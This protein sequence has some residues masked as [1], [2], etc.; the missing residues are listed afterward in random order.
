[1]VFLRMREGPV[2]L[3]EGRWWKVST[4]DTEK[5]SLLETSL[6]RLLSPFAWILKFSVNAEVGMLL[7]VMKVQTAG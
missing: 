3:H 5:L 6:W 7:G 1:M 4:G 2:S